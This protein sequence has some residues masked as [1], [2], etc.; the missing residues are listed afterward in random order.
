M[1]RKKIHTLRGDSP[2]GRRRVGA[3][4]SRVRR[5]PQEDDD[6]YFEQINKFEDE[7]DM[8]DTVDEVS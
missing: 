5:R 3:P 2:D 8:S 4:K 7:S 1:S 6:E